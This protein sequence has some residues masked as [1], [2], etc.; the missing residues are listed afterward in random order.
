MNPEVFCNSTLCLLERL[1]LLVLL[2]VFT[3][4]VPTKYIVKAVYA[5]LG[6]LFWHVIPVIDAMSIRDRQR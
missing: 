3:L 4:V 1:Q 2:F 5:C 6:F